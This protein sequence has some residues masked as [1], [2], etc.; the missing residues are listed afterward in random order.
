M[1]N[2]SRNLFNM[3][4]KILYPRGSEWRKWDLHVHSPLS[5]LNNQYPKN[6][7][8]S[9][10]WECFIDSLDKIRGFSVIGIADY[11][12]IDG[13][14]KLME[15]RDRGRLKNIDLILPNIE[16][17]LDTFV[18]KEKS[19]DIN[20]HVIFSEELSTEAI[21]N[22]FIGALQFQ[23]SGSVSGLVG[24]RQLTRQSIREAGKLIK[25]YNSIFK[26]DSDD[27]AGLK[28]ITVNLKQVQD[29]LGKDLFDGKFLF[30]LSGHEWADID[31]KQAYLTK[32]NFL[33]VAHILETGS[34]NTINWALGKKDLSRESFIKE[35][36]SLKPCMF[37]SDAHS[38]D[39]I[40]QPGED[41]FCWIKAD[42]T[43]KGLKQVIYEPEER[44]YIG[45]SPPKGKNDARVIDKIEVRNSNNWFDDNPI[46]LND[47][48]VSIIGEKGAGKTA[49]ADF[50]ALAGGD[51]NI[52]EEDSGSFVFKALKSSKQIEET[53]DNSKIT[54][55]WRDGS[56]D[57]ITISKDFRDY[58]NL[59][60][61]RYLSQSFIE[62]KCRPEKAEEL[63][64]EV[65]NIVFQYLPDQER[66]GQTTFID[67]K[68][69]RT[70]AIQIKTSRC[71]QD[72]IDLNGQIFGL[73]EEINSLDGKREEKGRLQTEIDQL[74]SQKPK[75]TSE[76]DKGIEKILGLLNNRK[77]QLTEQVARC[78]VLLSSIDTLKTKVE[79]LKT[80]VTK[81]LADIKSDLEF[82]GMGD[83]FEKIRF[84]VSSDFENALDNKKAEIEGQIIKIRGSAEPKEEIAEDKFKTP[85]ELDL[86]TL[87]G[88]YISNLFLYNINSLINI[89]EAK[90]SLAEDKRKTLRTFEE[91]IEKNQKRVNEL[92]KS[93]KEIEDIKIPLRPIKI[94]E[95]NEKYKSYFLFLQEEKKTREELYAPLREKLDKEKLG[96]KNQIEFFARIELD[97]ENFFKKA[98]DIVDF[99]K[100]GSYFHD[101]DSLF[102]KIKIIAE[103][104]E[105]VE[106]TD[107]FSLI[108]CLTSAKFGQGLI[109]PK[110]WFPI[111]KPYE[112]E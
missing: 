70:Q 107:V 59:R 86:G 23:A 22:E 28:N 32:K 88:E 8:G 21:E 87:T 100:S 81:Q 58:K 19:K 82:I 102:K 30:V 106:T 105:L 3:E 56:S 47:S 50:I 112:E 45:N 76:E 110:L 35:F 36:G 68:K 96:E 7:D 18:V 11:F 73:E 20:F 71:K 44:I 78:K 17:R 98:D 15:F 90:S 66:M 39:R 89:L 34:S 12:F 24:A 85:G 31:W 29:L 75:P 95:R 109:S 49:L 9:P 61:V 26:N 27:E 80:Y 111:T 37:G 2:N 65:E 53:I 104:I 46:L 10:D 4:P 60:K 52:K 25:E 93:I 108:D 67:I 97:V 101:K 40:C 13:Y 91:K 94:R 54:I 103:K 41:K 6:P 38:V 92:E 14:K 33:Q 63:Q 51:F 64:K 74:D 57:P 77:V 48:L 55:Y 16:L 69:K 62:R 42:P 84:S 1:G 99:A 5:G 79:D 72:I 43:F 83:S